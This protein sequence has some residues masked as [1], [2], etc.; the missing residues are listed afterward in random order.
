[1]YI[2][3]IHDNTVKPMQEPSKVHVYRLQHLD[4]LACQSSAH[5]SIDDDAL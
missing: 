4:V 5:V 2:L 1:M 3:A